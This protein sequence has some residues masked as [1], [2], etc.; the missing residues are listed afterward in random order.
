[1]RT[2]AGPPVLLNQFA[3]SSATAPALAQWSGL[4]PA[5]PMEDLS[6]RPVSPTRAL[7]PPPG[8]ART[9]TPPRTA[10]G[11][12]VRSLTPGGSSQA[13]LLNAA[14]P[15][16]VSPARVDMRGG[17]LLRMASN[18]QVAYAR[19]SVERSVSPIR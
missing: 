2:T 15:P 12:E 3:L 1:M 9:A 19:S 18:P 8:G 14:R 16:P 13:R 11:S 6:R 10:L 17:G 4:A 5:A 7:T